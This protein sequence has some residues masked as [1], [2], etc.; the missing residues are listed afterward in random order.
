MTARRDTPSQSDIYR[1]AAELIC[2]G[3]ASYFGYALDLAEQPDVELQDRMYLLFR[4]HPEDHRPHT[5]LYD[6]EAV[7]ALCF[8]SAM[9]E[10]GDA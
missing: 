9:V 8:M 5:D 3:S 1:K 4:Q 7:L 6:D 2:I 10:A